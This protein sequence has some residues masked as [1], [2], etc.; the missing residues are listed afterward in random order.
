MGQWGR[1]K[2]KM[3]QGGREKKK[4]RGE[5]ISFPNSFSYDLYM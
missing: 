3:G 1:E 4:K 5:S 2:K